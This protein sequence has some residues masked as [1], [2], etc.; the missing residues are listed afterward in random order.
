[1]KRF[2]L[3]SVVIAAILMVSAVSCTTLRETEG[4]DTYYD[5]TAPVLNRIYVDDPYR[6]TVVLERDPYTGRYYELG[7]VGI[8]GAG[9]YRGRFYDNYYGG[10]YNRPNTRYRNNR[11]YNTPRYDNRNTNNRN[12]TNNT[13]TTEQR[14]QQQEKREEV[15]QEARNKVLR[16]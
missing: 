14:N 5:R 6:G 10:P 11:T 8:Y 2:N 7:S 9:A 3:L 12:N 4:D 15:R 1:M 16:N 13:P